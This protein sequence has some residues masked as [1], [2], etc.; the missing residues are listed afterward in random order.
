M[1]ATN[2]P[3]PDY[4][5]RILYPLVGTRMLELGRKKTDGVTYKSYFESIGIDHTSI[6]WSGGFG[7]LALDLREPLDF[8]PFDMVTNFGTTEHV[9]DQEAVWKN[10]HNMVKVGGVYCGITPLEGDWKGHGDYY[11]R[12]EFFEKFAEN[13]YHIDYLD[14]GREAPHR[15]IDVRM[16][17]V[18]GKP[19]IMP[20]AETI[21]RNK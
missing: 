19:F 9:S 18:E 15:N 4:L 17:K 5:D 20:P 11:P 7:S 21:Y 8:E 2:S 10:I 16:T 6:D 13:G 3:I 12:I 14:I 1:T